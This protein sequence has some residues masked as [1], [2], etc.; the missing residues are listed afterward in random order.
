MADPQFT[1]RDK[2]FGVSLS[3]RSDSD[4]HAMVNVYS[5]D[6]GTWYSINTFDSAWIDDMI[7]VL[8]MAKTKLQHRGVKPKGKYSKGYRLRSRDV[9]ECESSMMSSSEEE[10]QKGM[11][12]K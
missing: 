8:E 12:R 9:V 4:D 6:D 1:T 10:Y 11:D 5:E 3:H 7:S 2:C